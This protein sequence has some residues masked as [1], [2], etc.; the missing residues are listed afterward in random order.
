MGDTEKKIITEVYEVL[1]NISLQR[2]RFTQLEIN[3]YY[4]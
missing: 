3:I 4:I 2:V 1:K